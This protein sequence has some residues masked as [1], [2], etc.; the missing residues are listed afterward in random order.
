MYQEKGKK[1]PQNLGMA[2]ILKRKK[3][4][5]GNSPLRNI[6]GRITGRGDGVEDEAELATLGSGGDSVEADVE[7]GAVGRVG[8][9]R[10]RVGDVELVLLLAP[11]R[12]L[13]AGVKGFLS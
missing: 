10:V 5:W 2:E 9:L 12:A 13:E 6:F 7:L 8:V 4:G 3:G 11:V 1:I